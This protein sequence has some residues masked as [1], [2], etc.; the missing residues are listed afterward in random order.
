MKLLGNFEF[1]LIAMFQISIAVRLKDNRI[2]VAEIEKP[3]EANGNW[4]NSP[5]ASEKNEAI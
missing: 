3:V 4:P 5:K 2:S 1:F